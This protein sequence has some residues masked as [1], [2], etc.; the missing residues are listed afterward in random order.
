MKTYLAIAFAFLFVSQSYAQ[1]II[2]EIV[3]SRKTDFIAIMARL[4]YLSTEEID[5]AKLSWGSWTGNDKGDEYIYY[6]NNGESL[7][8]RKEKET[9]GSYSRSSEK[10]VLY[11]NHNKSKV[12]DFKETLGKKYLVEDDMPKYKWKIL[13]EIKE[14]QGYLCMKAETYDK[15]KDQIIHAWF[16]D[17]IFFDGGPEGYSGLPGMILELNINND[18]A[19]ITATKVNLV[20]AQEELPLPKK[21]KGKKL[22]IAEFDSMI[23]SYISDCIEAERNPYW[24]IRY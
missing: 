9:D 14:I 12:K 13:N 21:M 18:D 10:Y 6:F 19:I 5:R 15:S 20:T 24:R 7:Y 16:T 3:Y 8:T 22:T 17:G 4:P 11:R 2:G 23:E 1:D